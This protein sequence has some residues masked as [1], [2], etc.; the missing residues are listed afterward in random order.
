MKSCDKFNTKCHHRVTNHSKSLHIHIEKIH[1][2]K[3]ELRSIQ[4]CPSVRALE[5]Q[6][7]SPTLLN[8]ELLTP[9]TMWE[10]RECTN[11]HCISK[12]SIFLVTSIVFPL[13][14][15]ISETEMVQISQLHVNLAIH[16]PSE[17]LQC[18]RAEMP[19]ANPDWQ[20]F[21]QWVFCI[22][23]LSPNLHKKISVL[24]KHSIFHSG[25]TR[26]S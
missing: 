21:E 20:G 23:G 17:Q 12:S 11:Q 19:L 7:K 2:Q 4:G 24:H 3:S 1:W 5:R 8:R 22:P 13:N 16:N 14:C 25:I 18:S 6:T 9:C 26:F 10:I 15:A